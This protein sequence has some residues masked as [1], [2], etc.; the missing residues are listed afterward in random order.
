MFTGYVYGAKGM[1]KIIPNTSMGSL[2]HVYVY[3]FG[4]KPASPEET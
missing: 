4:W 1:L 3:V 2:K